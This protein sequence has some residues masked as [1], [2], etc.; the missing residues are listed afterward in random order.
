ML[1]YTEGSLT[2]V[3]QLKSLGL[4][5]YGIFQKVLTPDNW[6]ILKGNLENESNIINLVNKAKTYICK[7]GERIVGMIY[8]VPNGNPADV[9]PAEW[10][11]VRVLGVHPE[12]SGKGIARKLVQMCLDEAVKSGEQTMALHTSEF[13]NAARH[14]YEGIGFTILREI[15]QRFGKR[16]WLYTLDLNE[17]KERTNT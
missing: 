13:M 16:Y 15:D 6:Q 7:D 3:P 12:Y 2:D 10:C 5:S 11:Y 9:Y 1:T 14:L 8:L 4:D 17:Y